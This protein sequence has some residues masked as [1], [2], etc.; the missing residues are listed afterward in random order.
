M[1]VELSHNIELEL[2]GTVYNVTYRE[3]TD[4]ERR[5]IEKKNAPA[6]KLSEK[7]EKLARKEQL[8]TQRLEAYKALG[9]AK[10]E[11]DV[12][13][14]L[15]KIEEKAG[16]LEEEFNALNG[17]DA[18]YRLYVEEFDICIG[19]K[20]KELLRKYVEEHFSFQKI[21]YIIKK[22]IVTT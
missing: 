13:D 20:D 10:G 19:G 9:D 17:S 8:L 16:E 15:E 3:M 6:V 14:K 21:L 5:K 7:V 18:A 12:L 11:L 22:N 4:K 1:K 2:D